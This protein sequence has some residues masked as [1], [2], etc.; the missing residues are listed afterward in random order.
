MNILVCA[1]ITDAGLLL[2]DNATG[3]CADCQCRIQFRPHAPRSKK[4]CFR[5]AKA[6]LL[7]P[8]AEVQ[9]TPRMAEDFQTWLRK[10]KH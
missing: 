9:I 6:L 7:E 4:V 10:Q 5:C 2:P 3:R 8:G 1:P